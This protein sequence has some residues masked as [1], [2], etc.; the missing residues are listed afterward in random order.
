VLRLLERLRSQGTPIYALGLQS[1]LCGDCQSFNPTKFRE[2]LK[3][4]ASLGLKIMITEMDVM[5]NNLPANI[6]QRDRMIAEAY[7]DYLSIALAQKAVISVTTW[8][9]S[10]RYTWLAGFKPR[11]DKADVRP[12]PFDRNF[13]PKLAWNAIA[14]AF[15]RAPSR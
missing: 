2:F 11:A 8:G 12:L 1:H 15:D 9:L 13:K 10:D 7:A 4:V 6:N 3:N 14:N 5:D